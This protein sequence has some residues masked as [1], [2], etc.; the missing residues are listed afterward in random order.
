VHRPHQEGSRRVGQFGD[1]EQLAVKFV[2][3]ALVMMRPVPGN[4]HDRAVCAG[5]PY[6]DASV[7]VQAGDRD[8]AG[9]DDLA[10][11]IIHHPYVGHVPASS[12]PLS[13]AVGRPH[14]GPPSH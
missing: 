9:A 7:V 3:P 5:Q 11:V 6:R 4:R 10:T 12:R 14:S 2:R 13:H 8:I 1:A